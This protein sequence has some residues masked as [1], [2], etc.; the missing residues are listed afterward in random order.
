MLL[1]VLIFALPLWVG[2]GQKA[3]RVSSEVKDKDARTAQQLSRERYSDPNGF[4][5]ITPPKGWRIKGY[6]EDPRGKVA[7]IGPSGVELRVLSKVVDYET[8]EDRVEELKNIEKQMGIDT[9]IERITFLGKP[10]IRRSFTIKGISVLFIDLF[11]GNI[12]HNIMYSAKKG[13]YD[14]YL[15]LATTSMNTY[16]TVPRDASP[17]E[18]KKHAL[19]H[20]LRLAQLFFELGDLD[21]SLEFVKEGLEIDP[22]NPALLELKKKI[23]GE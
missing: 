19:A 11:E 21:S 18:A 3:E 1:L 15:A 9:N 7:F 5:K 14:K 17:E 2:C 4:F 10:A 13:K 22:D 12:T 16:E 20:K 6:P 8:F 23:E